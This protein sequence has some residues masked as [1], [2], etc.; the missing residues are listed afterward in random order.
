MRENPPTFCQRDRTVFSLQ[1]LAPSPQKKKKKRICAFYRAPKLNVLHRPL[2]ICFPWMF[3]RTN[4]VSF[5][6]ALEGSPV[7]GVSPCKALPEQG[8]PAQAKPKFLKILGVQHQVRP[9][10]TALGSLAHPT[11]LWGRKEPGYPQQ[12]HADH[13]W[14]VPMGSISPS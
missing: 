3:V 1:R 2:T 6:P 9:E 13:P 4:R 11:C 12:G 5:L 14:A 8:E 7:Q 10:A